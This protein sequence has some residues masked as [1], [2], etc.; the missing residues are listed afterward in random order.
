L[1]REIAEKGDSMIKNGTSSSLRVTIRTV[2]A[3]ALLTSGAIYGSSTQVVSGMHYF[4][5]PVPG[6]PDTSRINAPVPGSP[7]TSR[8]NA[9]VPGSPDTSLINAPV[10]GSPDTSRF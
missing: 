4:N 5:A 8:I 10:P 9:P 1:L 6:S 3:A 2:I 7:D